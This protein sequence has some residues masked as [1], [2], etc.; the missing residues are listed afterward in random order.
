ML[1]VHFAS[2]YIETLLFTICI[3]SDRD[4]DDIKAFVQVVN[5]IQ[6]KTVQYKSIGWNCFSYVRQILQ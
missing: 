2:T 4:N 3:Q 1:S 5:S 6:N